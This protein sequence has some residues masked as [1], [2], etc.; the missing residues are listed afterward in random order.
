[1]V[2]AGLGI[3]LALTIVPILIGGSVGAIGSVLAA[4]PVIG[5]AGQA[6]TATALGI[7][8]MLMESPIWGMFGIAA[9]AL[10]TSGFMLSFWIPILP[11]IRVAF[12]VLTWMI[13]VFEAVVMV[14][15]AALAHLTTEGEGVAGGAKGIWVIWLNILLRPVLMVIG[16][17]GAMIA[18]N[19]FVAYFTSVYWSSLRE[20]VGGV[21]MILGIVV[22]TV[23][24]VGVIYMVA[25]SLFKMIDLVP[26]AVSKYMGGHAD[27]SFDQDASGMVSGVGGLAKGMGDA[28]AA[29]KKAGKEFGEHIKDEKH[30]GT[31]KV[32]G[33]S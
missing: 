29:D 3:Y 30:K 6:V 23:L 5:G 27:T 7:A 32:G 16:Y 18:F 22:Y 17:V 21:Q 12:G 24:Y 31:P 20:S 26:A 11:L 10:L 33:T 14:P 19:T 15:I 13:A 28:G 8:E 9:G 4:I 1:M 2:M 25:N